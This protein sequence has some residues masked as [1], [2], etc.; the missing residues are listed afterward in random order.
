M[1]CDSNIWRGGSSGAPLTSV[2]G[3]SRQ[4]EREIDNKIKQS[5]HWCFQLEPALSSPY[6]LDTAYI[7]FFKGVVSLSQNSN[8]ERHRNELKQVQ[9]YVIICKTYRSVML[10]QVNISYGAVDSSVE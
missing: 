4:H 3:H 9:Y 7:I 6:N 8:S 10:F 1:L 5:S 2:V